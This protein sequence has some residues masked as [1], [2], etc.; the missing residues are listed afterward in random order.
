MAA[1][2]NSIPG[3]AFVAAS[4]IPFDDQGASMLPK[5][6]LTMYSDLM[7]CAI[8]WCRFVS[9]GTE[10]LSKSLHRHTVCELHYILEGNLR[11]VFDEELSLGPGEFV[12][13]PQNLAHRILCDHPQTRKLVIGFSIKTSLPGINALL[14]E[15]Q[16]PRHAVASFSMAQLTQALADK[17]ANANL[18]R[19][20]SAGYI[21]Y[22]LILEAA[23]TLLSSASTAGET[24]TSFRKKDTAARKRDLLDFVQDNISNHITVQDVARHLG[25]E[26]RQANR[27]CQQDFHCTIHQLIVKVRLRHVQELL[28][29]T[30]FSMAEIAELTGFS[31]A[32]A[33]I[34]HF[35]SNMGIPPGKYRQI[36]AETPRSH[37]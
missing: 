28:D 19:S 8:G 24:E 31:S 5:V 29:Q 16:S 12:L 4:D 35:K 36:H 14:N 3:G 7:R 13:I 37:T 26:V 22:S 2:Q 27:V 25:F 18:S 34:R 30:Q 9:E 1:K 21:A 6:Q 32:Y 17:A 15:S 33:L 11:F 20:M 10:R 23:D